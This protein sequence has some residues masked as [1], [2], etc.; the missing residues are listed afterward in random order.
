VPQ[1]LRAHARA[2]ARASIRA[3]DPSIAVVRALVDDPILADWAAPEALRLLGAPRTP[4]EAAGRLIV[5][6]RGADAAR[7]GVGA[8]AV[9][10]EAVDEVVVLGPGA[11]SPDRLNARVGALGRE[12]RL[13][14]LDS[15][16]DSSPPEPGAPPPRESI[17]RLAAWAAP[18]RVLCLTLVDPGSSSSTLADTNLDLRVIENGGDGRGAALAEAR[19]RGLDATLLTDRLE[20]EA[21][22]VGR[23]LARVG[24]AI[25][26]GLGGLVPPACAIASGRV[27]GGERRHRDVVTAAA[28]TLGPDAGEVAV[29]CWSPG[30]RAPDLFAVLVA[31]RRG[32]VDPSGSSGAS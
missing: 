3:H 21:T 29:E 13:L 10:G 20:G 12:D 6:A 18:A 9:F 26:A 19:L 31:A 1:E 5:V 17:E 11:E 24:L 23:A 8:S 16:T 27:R 25:R 4:G 32:E 2:I 30:P 15:R 14:L 28:E 22:S 7:M